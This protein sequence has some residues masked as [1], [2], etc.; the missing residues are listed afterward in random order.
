MHTRKIYILTSFILLLC[1]SCEKENP[2]S[3]SDGLLNGTEVGIDC[4]GDC[5]PCEVEMEA[6]EL[7]G[8][9]QQYF[10][11][12]DG[13]DLREFYNVDDVFYQF[14]MNGAFNGLTVQNDAEI[15]TI[16]DGTFV[17]DESQNILTIDNGWVN[18]Y[19]VSYENSNLVLQKEL[20]GVLDIQKFLPID[21]ELCSAVNCIDGEC[22]FGYCVE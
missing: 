16:F 17:H 7:V 15:K 20:K 6:V 12:E 18:Q 10:H 22:H 14:A 5:D 19:D 21:S 8:V 2:A 3:C 13:N 9:W 4:G 11:E 1:Y